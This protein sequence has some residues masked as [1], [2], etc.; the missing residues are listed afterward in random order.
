MKAEEYGDLIDDPRDFF[1]MYIFLES[2]E[3]CRA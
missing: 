3:I 1:R 2:S